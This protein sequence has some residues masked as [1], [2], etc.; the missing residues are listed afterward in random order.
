MVFELHRHR[1]PIS[2]RF[3]SNIR[4]F[5]S[6]DFDK[7]NKYYIHIH[8]G[9][10]IAN[11]IGINENNFKVEFYIDSD[12][13]RLWM[14]K[15][16]NEKS[17]FTYK[18]ALFFTNYHLKLAWYKFVPNPKDMEKNLLHFKIEDDNSLIIDFDKKI[19]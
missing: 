11:K 2:S 12:N 8:I 7:H 19:I 6:K 9:V 17:V 5:F 3:A 10:E 15:P 4:A 16:A 14:I 18:P 13:P 1:R